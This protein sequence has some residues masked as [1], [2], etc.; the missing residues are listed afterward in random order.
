MRTEPRGLSNSHHVSLSRSVCI[1]SSLQFV[2]LVIQS[3]M[4]RHGFLNCPLTLIPDPAPQGLI[5]TLNGF[6]NIRKELRDL[7][8]SKHR[9][10]VR[11]VAVFL[12]AAP[13][14]GLLSPIGFRSTCAMLRI[15]HTNVADRHVEN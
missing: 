9:L 4:I 1:H 6:E 7:F 13:R 14:S 3:L 5:K 8:R 2:D 15:P 10:T 12:W 11:E